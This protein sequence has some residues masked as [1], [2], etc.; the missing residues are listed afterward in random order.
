MIIRSKNKESALHNR[1]EILQQILVNSPKWYYILQRIFMSEKEK[2]KYYSRYMKSL[3]K[4][5][6]IYPQFEYSPY[7]VMIINVIGICSFIYLLINPSLDQKEKAAYF[8]A[9][10]AS[11]A[12]FVYYI[13]KRKPDEIRKFAKEE[14]N[15]QKNL[16][17]A[18]S[19]MNSLQLV[20]TK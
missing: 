20:H 19:Y 18:A 7:D 17:K 5:Y 10:I 8:L 16:I 12:Y 11:L 2:K 1:A 13:L 6:E 14:L 15:V 3:K 4:F 9:S